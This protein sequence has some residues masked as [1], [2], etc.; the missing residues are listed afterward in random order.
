[1]AT[2]E[3]SPLTAARVQGTRTPGAA[4]G[5]RGEPGRGRQRHSRRR[6][7]PP[8]RVGAGHLRR[9]Q[10]PRLQLR[11]PGLPQNP[12]ECGVLF[13]QDS[14]PLGG[15]DG[16]YILGLIA[17]SVAPR[18]WSFPGVWPRN[19]FPMRRERL[20]TEPAEGS[21]LTRCG[22]FGRP[23]RGVSAGSCRPRHVRGGGVSVV[24]CSSIWEP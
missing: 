17:P 21:T 14:L 6:P 15:V 4:S 7:S 8:G 2:A 5:I 10:Q 1:M 16:S 13:L 18:S 9:R 12:A 22:G 24:S 20:N 19:Q 23:A 3:R 11:G